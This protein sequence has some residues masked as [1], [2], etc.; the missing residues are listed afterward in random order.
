FPD[1]A[2][3]TRV[4]DGALGLLAPGGR[5]FVG[6][7][8]HQRTVR[9]LHTAVQA[10]RAE[11][12]ERLRAAVEQ[13]VLLEK[14]LVLDPGFFSLWAEENSAGVDVRLKRGA[15]H[16]ELTRH[17][18]EVVIHRDPARATPVADL[19]EREFTSLAELDGSATPVRLTGIPNPRLTGELAAARALTR[20]GSLNEVRAQLKAARGVDPEELHA[21]AARSGHRVVTTW[22]PDDPGTFEA[23]VLP[24]GPDGPLTGVHRAPSGRP[25]SALAGNPAGSR[26][27]GGLLTR[28]RDR[29]AERLPAYLV[30]SAILAIDEIP[31]T[32]NGKVDR[33]ALP[34]QW[35][36]TTARAPR[37]PVE[38]VLC[39]LFAELLGRPTVG[40]DESFFD[41][42]GH[43]LL[44][45]RLVSR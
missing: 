12:V 29:L 5:I 25:L 39:G 18:Y 41:L 40:V 45:T 32:V 36:T 37:T 35:P 17:R 20:H 38:E 9:A 21:W 33:D 26:F 13:A 4:L 1:A 15:P 10:E 30:P 2:Y 14:E 7:V 31:L 44:A 27:L 22:S 19:P 3:L 11:S 28:L 6:D 24:A 42:G 8:R 16:N 34:D 43:S 23:L